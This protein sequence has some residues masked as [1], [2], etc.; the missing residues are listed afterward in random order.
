MRLP[1]YCITNATSMQQLGTCG[2]ARRCYITTPSWP[3]SWQMCWVLLLSRGSWCTPLILYTCANGN[4]TNQIVGYVQSLVVMHD[5]L[6]MAA[7]L[8][9]VPEICRA[10]CPL[11]ISRSDAPIGLR[12]SRRQIGTKPSDVASGPH[13][14][15]LGGTQ[16]IH[17]RR[18]VQWRSI[19]FTT[20]SENQLHLYT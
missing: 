5:M 11:H 18:L 14:H 19:F 6:P 13:S 10:W 9:K 17:S 16:W 7:R 15:L 4:T 3:V 8:V 1:V 12:C 2:G 20:A